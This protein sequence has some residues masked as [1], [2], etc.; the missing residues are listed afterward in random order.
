MFVNWSTTAKIR[1]RI[2]PMALQ[3]Y[4]QLGARESTELRTSV[5][6]VV[7]VVPARAF[8]ESDFN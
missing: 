3:V 5:V 6:G 4:N 8:L 7:Y 1:D 2:Y